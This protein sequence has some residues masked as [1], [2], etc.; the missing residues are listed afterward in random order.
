MK[1]GLSRSPFAWAVIAVVFVIVAAWLGRGRYE[2][3]VVGTTAP[4]FQAEDLEGDLVSVADYAGRVVL[5]NVWATWCPP[6]LEEMPSMQRLYEE[7][8]QDDFEI[9]AVSVDAPFGEL[10]RGGMP[11]GQ[12]EAFAQRFGLTFPIL[13]DP[14]GRIQRVYQTTGVPETFLIGRDGIIY[15]KIAGGAHWDSQANRELV[16][17]LLGG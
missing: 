10:D 17:R 12:V 11:G 1:R 15:K 5:L 8:S 14:E 7:F 16:G 2:P 13:R 4:D 9:L 6:C 3:V